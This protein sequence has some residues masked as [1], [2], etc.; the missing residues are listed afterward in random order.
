MRLPFVVVYVF[1]IAGGVYVYFVVDVVV[2]VDAVVR[3][4]IGN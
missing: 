1:V 2:I 4:Q 3:I